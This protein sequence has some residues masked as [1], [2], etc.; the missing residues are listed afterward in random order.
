M[1]R[2]LVRF[3]AI[4]VASTIAHLLLFLLFRGVMGAIAANVVALLLTSIVNT[5]A[6]RRLTF[7]VRG[8]EGAARHQ[9]QGLIIFGLGLALTTGA[10]ALLGHLVPAASR[11]VELAVIVAANAAATVLRFVLF[12]AWV[13]RP[14]P[15]TVAETPR[16]SE[17]PA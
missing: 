2:Q 1:P 17:N 4:G 12:R 5:A 16:T 15:V 10:L 6:N 14:R 8:G 13:F 11:A 9:F 7:G 3:A